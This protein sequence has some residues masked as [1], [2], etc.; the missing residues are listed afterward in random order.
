MKKNKWSQKE[1]EYALSI[2]EELPSVLIPDVF[3]SW[4]EKNG[5]P[6][7]TARALHL[8]AQSLGC[9]ILCRNSSQYLAVS[10]IASALNI[11]MFK[12]YAWRDRLGFPLKKFNAG[13]CYVAKNSAISFFKKHPYLLMGM[14]SGGIY[15]LTD[16]KY[17]AEKLSK[18]PAYRRQFPRHYAGNKQFDSTKELCLYFDIN[19]IRQNY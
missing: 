18:L 1:T 7:R 5:Y 13:Y 12:L 16:C 2:F 3:N 17:M 19:K 10:E 14:P 4:A 15:W 8:K 11:G 9:S 6:L